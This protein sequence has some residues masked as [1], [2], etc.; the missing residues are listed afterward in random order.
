MIYDK[1]LLKTS[2]RIVLNTVYPRENSEI[3]CTNFG[4]IF[5][6]S[7]ESDKQ[8]KIGKMNVKVARFSET[9]TLT[10]RLTFR[11]RLR[12]CVV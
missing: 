9:S 2:L 3:G 7:F 8:E 6:F 12:L 11:R 5:F 4:M 10:A 1:F